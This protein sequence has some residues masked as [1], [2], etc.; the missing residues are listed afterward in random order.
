M[1]VPLGNGTRSAGIAGG[2]V[3]DPRTLVAGSPARGGSATA[4]V[5]LDWLAGGLLLEASVRTTINSTRMTRPAPTSSAHQPRLSRSG[6]G[7]GARAGRGGAGVGATGTGSEP[8][9]PASAS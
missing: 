7:D 4:V 5:A 3:P 2:R 6:G 8:G 1:L 9:G